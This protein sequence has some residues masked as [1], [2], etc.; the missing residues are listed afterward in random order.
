VVMKPA[1]C[2]SARSALIRFTAVK[3][4]ICLAQGYR[5]ALDEFPDVPTVGEFV[6]GYEASAWYGIGA[7]EG[8][9]A[10]IVDKLNKE[11]NAAL[12]NKAG[13]MAVDSAT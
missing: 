7:P 12:A 9:P 6:P 4:F 3:V 10:D 8:T 2:S 5:R 11:T 1:T 13:E